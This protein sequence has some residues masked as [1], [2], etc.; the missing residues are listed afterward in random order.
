MYENRQYGSN[1]R[2]LLKALHE[3]AGE[4]EGLAVSL[5]DRA[6]RWRPSPDEWSALEVVGYLRDS[7][8]ED[9]RAV[10]SMLRRDHAPIA[11]RRAH[12]SPGEQDFHA[13][14][15]EDLIW[16]FL[17]V[18]EELVWLL[19]GAEGAWEHCGAHPHRGEVSLSTYVHEVN[20][21]DLEAMWMLR[22]RA[23]AFA[24]Q[25]GTASRPT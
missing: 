13:A 3:V 16:D 8:R 15:V 7:E 5:D 12:L 6:L 9:V 20:E 19:Y 10:R 14:R 24:A 1:A 23:E 17:T 2:W 21:R 11:E 25:A 22:R 18:R 4:I